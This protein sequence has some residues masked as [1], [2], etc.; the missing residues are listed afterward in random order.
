MPELVLVF[1]GRNHAEL[2]LGLIGQEETSASVGHDAQANEEA[3]LWSEGEVF[4]MHV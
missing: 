3:G 1:L 4:A 2:L